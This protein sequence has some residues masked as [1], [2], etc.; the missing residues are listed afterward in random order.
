MGIKKVSGLWL[1]DG[2]N[3][4]YMSGDVKDPI[5]AG[6]KLMVFKNDRKRDDRDPDYTLN[7]SIDDGDGVARF[8]KFEAE[9]TG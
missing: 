8:P 4:K 1:K 7:I 5:P 2:K 6:S 3:G 9:H